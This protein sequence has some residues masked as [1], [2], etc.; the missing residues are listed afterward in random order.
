MMAKKTVAAI[1]TTI[2]LALC[3]PAQADIYFVHN[4]HLGTPQTISDKDQQIVWQ[5]DYEPFGTAQVTTEE[6]EINIRFPGQ[7]YDEETGLHYNYFRMYDPSTGR[8]LESDP[9]G[10]GGGLNTYLYA[11]SN[12][13]LNSDPYGLWS[14]SVGAGGT[15]QWNALG[16]GAS[17]SFSADSSGNVCMQFTTC[18]GLGFGYFGGLGF[19]GGYST[20]DLC[21]GE[22]ESTGPYYESGSGPGGSGSAQFGENSVSGATGLFDVGAGYAGGIQHCKSTTICL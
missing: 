21:E 20:D 15:F 13:F 10:L 19:T 7:Y 5:A 1:Y 17:T 2:L 8:Y 16:G 22:S 4:D 6:L 14:V 18:G 9:I 11:D 3:S 12:P